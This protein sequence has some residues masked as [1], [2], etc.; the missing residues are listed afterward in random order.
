[1]VCIQRPDFGGGEIFFDGE[2]IRKDGLFRAGTLAR[3]KPRKI[4]KRLGV[5]RE[6]PRAFSEFWKAICLSIRPDF[7]SEVEDN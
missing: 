7:V 6:I 1:M 3:V 5:N 4:K 2:L